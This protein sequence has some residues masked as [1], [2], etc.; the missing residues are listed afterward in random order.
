MYRWLLTIGLSVAT[1]VAAGFFYQHRTAFKQQNADMQALQTRIQGL[2]NVAAMLASREQQ[3]QQWSSLS[4]RVRSSSFD[5]DKWEIY[6]VAL[7]SSLTWPEFNDLMLSIQNANS[8][9]AGYWF[10]P[11]S[12]LV[13]AKSH[14]LQSRV[15]SS[16]QTNEN[17]PAP[18]EV[19]LKGA[20]LM[21]Q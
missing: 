4:E 8:E 15:H 20:F 10:N 16:G 21:R 19:Q 2:H 17:Q 1:V 5:P 3:A 6:P 13:K 9:D 18:L 12:L 11:Q 7:T 14:T